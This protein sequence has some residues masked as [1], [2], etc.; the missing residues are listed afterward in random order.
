MAQQRE[1]YAR[2]RYVVS[3][4]AVFGPHGSDIT[5]TNDELDARH[6][7]ARVEPEKLCNLRRR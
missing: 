7:I 3:R 5:E 4:D 6:Y 2:W 1:V